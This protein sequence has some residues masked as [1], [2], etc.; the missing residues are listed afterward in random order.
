ML[1]FLSSCDEHD[2]CFFSVDDHFVFF[3]PFLYFMKIVVELHFNC[4]VV[5]PVAVI[6]ESS[7]YMSTGALTFR[8]ISFMNMMNRS[9]P[10]MDP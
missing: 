5:F 9:E 2:L 7:S 1:P 3:T 6:V 8:G 10:N 4:L